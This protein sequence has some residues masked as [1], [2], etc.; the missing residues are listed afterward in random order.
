MLMKAEGR[1]LSKLFYGP[2]LKEEKANSTLHY[3]PST[4]RRTLTTRWQQ[5][6][7]KDEGEFGS[8]V[9]FVPVN[10]QRTSISFKFQRK[11]AAVNKP[12]THN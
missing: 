6:K 5:R 2:L 11:Q 1:A 3:T 10:R 9:V 4:H 7:K 8:V 12:S